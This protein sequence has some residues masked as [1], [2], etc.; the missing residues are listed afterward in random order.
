MALTARMIRTHLPHLADWRW[1]RPFELHHLLV[2]SLL[3]GLLFQ[4]LAP[5]LRPSDAPSP[6]SSGYP[7]EPY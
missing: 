5:L 2:A 3:L 6:G 4:L 7:T 1:R